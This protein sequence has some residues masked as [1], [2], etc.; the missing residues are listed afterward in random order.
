MGDEDEREGRGVI[1]TR[2]LGR[3]QRDEGVRE[4]WL[5]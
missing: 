4:G 5:R 1:G 2:R 3:G